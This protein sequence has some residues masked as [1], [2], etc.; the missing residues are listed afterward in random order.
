MVW[1]QIGVRQVIAGWDE[2]IL[3]DGKDV[4]PM[5]VWRIHESTTLTHK[6]QYC[7]LILLLVILANL[8]NAANLRYP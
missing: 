2:G 3:G 4:P 1:L 7:M 6:D 5:K 8:F